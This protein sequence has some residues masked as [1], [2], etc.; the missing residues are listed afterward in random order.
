MLLIA[1]NNFFIRGI[2]VI[3]PEQKKNLESHLLHCCNLKEIF[4]DFFHYLLTFR[5]KIMI[6]AIHWCLAYQF[7]LI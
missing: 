2:F 6:F 4:I 3:I 5:E 7:M 1:I